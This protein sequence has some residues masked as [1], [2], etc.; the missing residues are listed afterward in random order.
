MLYTWDPLALTNVVHWKKKREFRSFT[1]FI[2]PKKEESDLREYYIKEQL[3][4]FWFVFLLS[5]CTVLFVANPPMRHKYSSLV[6]SMLDIYLVGLVL[7]FVEACRKDG[8]F[9]IY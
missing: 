2:P 5:V 1:F 9:L 4:K 8:K 3:R 6:D 7:Y